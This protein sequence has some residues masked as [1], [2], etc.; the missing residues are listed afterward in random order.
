MT[1]P[2]RIM[3]LVAGVW[4]AETLATAHNLGIFDQIAEYGPL[5]AEEV[6]DRNA[7]EVRP[8]DL[9]LST[10][11]AL[12]LLRHEDG[13]YHNTEITNDYLVP[14]K[15]YYFGDAIRLFS[16]RYDTWLNLPEA[17]RKNAPVSWNPDTQDSLF[18]AEAPQAT[19]WDGMHALSVYSARCLGEVHDFTQHQRLLDIGGGGAA[20]D[21]ELCRTYPHLQ[22]TIFDLPFA[23]ERT[24]ERV[25]QAGLQERI[26]FHEGDFLND[27]E[28][29]TGHDVILLSMILHDWAEETNRT[30]LEKCFAALPSGG[31]IIVSELILDDD[32][33]GPP[34]AALMGINMLVETWGKN[35]TAAEY[36]GW[37]SD[38]GFTSIT[39]H[40]FDAPGANGVI[41]AK[42]D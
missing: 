34:L 37:L 20:Y 5:T 8:A 15:R 10:C 35:Y 1:T 42:K 28:L 13:R 30:L 7:I 23:I 12:G 26:A 4:S 25:V 16:G 18:H 24:S 6:A 33:N 41:V 27:S 14:G 38:A 9:L 32:R 31:S 3:D 17:V 29:P 39:Q 36:R 11:A 40:T 19:F 22:T 21:I 2:T